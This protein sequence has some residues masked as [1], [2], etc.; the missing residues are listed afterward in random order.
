MRNNLGEIIFFLGRGGTLA[1]LLK[2]MNALLLNHTVKKIPVK[3]TVKKRQLEFY[4]KKTV[5]T[6]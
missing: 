4:R 6:F 2:L 5:A 3:F 1:N